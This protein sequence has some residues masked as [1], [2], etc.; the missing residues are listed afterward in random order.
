MLKDVIHQ[1]INEQIRAFKLQVITSDG[2]NLGVIDKSE[3]L[4]LAREEG[5]DLVLISPEGAET[6]IAKIMDF[7]KAIYAKKKKFA[8]SKKKQKVIKVKEI[9]IRPKIGEHDFDTK[10]N[11]GADFLREGMKLKVTLQFR[12]RENVTKNEVGRAL[13]DRVTTL[14]QAK[15]L[16]N[17]VLEGEFSAGQLWSRI[18]FLK[19]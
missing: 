13:F 4:R 5:F 19:K 12:G 6:P 9:K 1:P 17:V 15:E 11:Q 2:R 3:G 8:E 14:L 18:Y 7:G 10:M 16:G